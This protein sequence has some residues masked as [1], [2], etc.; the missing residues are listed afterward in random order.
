MGKFRLWALAIALVPLSSCALPTHDRSVLK[1][2]KAESLVILATGQTNTDLTIPKDQWP[3]TIA[4]LKPKSVTVSS[5][6]VDILVKPYFDGGWGY[7]I[8]RDARQL[9]DPAGRY[10]KLDQGVYWYHPY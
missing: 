3:H 6:G 7:L 1:A 9:P 10:E 8:P 2:I 4:S 5:D